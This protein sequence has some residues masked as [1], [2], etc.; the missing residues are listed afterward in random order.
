M[1]SRR[2][3][4]TAGMLGTLATGKAGEAAAQSDGQVVA[5]ALNRVVESLDEIKASMDAGL[6]GNTMS[7]GSL[8]VIKGKLETW[9][10]T[11][12][13]FPEYWDVGI[14][15]FLEIYD[16]HIRQKQEIKISR[17]ADQRMAIQ[18]MFTQYVL[19]YENEPNYI[20]QQPYD[21]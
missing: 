8:G 2:E 13:K 21:R 14:S 15:V 4:V 16:W 7:Y 11:T 9:V 19:R 6:R 3:V 17:I 5:A 1:I 12:G 10:K 20:G 18:W